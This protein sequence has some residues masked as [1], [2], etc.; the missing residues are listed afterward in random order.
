MYQLAICARFSGGVFLMSVYNQQFFDGQVDESHRAASLI[1]PFIFETINPKSILDY[2]CGTGSW[3]AVAK[4]IGAN[5]VL[6]IDGPW[7]NKDMLKIH[8]DEFVAV[9]SEIDAFPDVGEF[10]LAISMEV[11][12]HLND[13]T[14]KAALDFLSQRSKYILL[15]VAIPGQ[16]GTN[17]INEQWQSYYARYLGERGFRVWDL[18]R[19]K[20]WDE[21]NIP[22]FYRQNA[23]FFVREDLADQ[24]EICDAPLLD[25]VHPE[26]MN[27][28]QLY[29]TKREAQIGRRIERGIR[30]L[31]KS[32]LGTARK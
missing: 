4:Q 5:R 16:G 23:L 27:L 7:V 22:Y 13:R 1:L 12:E 6:G 24:H 11:L 32:I 14:A 29:K 18:V 15:S 9:D 17:H 8:P 31:T 10:D 3:A 20:F 2:G 25:A 28:L 26:I 30:G 21:P 19:P